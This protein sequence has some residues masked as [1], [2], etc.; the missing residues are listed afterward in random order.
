MLPARRK[1]V[2]LRLACRSTEGPAALRE[3]LDT[4]DGIGEIGGLGGLGA[5]AAVERVELEALLACEQTDFLAAAGAA[6]EPRDASQASHVSHVSH[7]ANRARLRVV[8]ARIQLERRD[9]AQAEADALA[10]LDEAAD[11]PD[12]A[13]A[14]ML[15]A[16]DTARRNGVAWTGELRRQL[17]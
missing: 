1:V 17:R 14:F 7:S 4:L 13:E 3:L 10:A 9:A 6:S 8:R 16:L 12:R 11:P 5:G 2:R 15:L